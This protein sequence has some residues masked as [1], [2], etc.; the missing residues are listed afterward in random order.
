MANLL[1][2]VLLTTLSSAPAIRPTFSI[3]GLVGVSGTLFRDATGAVTTEGAPGTG[4]YTRTGILFAGRI[5]VE[6]EV[7]VGTDLFRNFWHVAGTLEVVPLRV[8]TVAAGPV[9]GGFNTSA[10]AVNDDK[11]A[12]YF[13]GTLRL[14][15]HPW[16]SASRYGATF[17]L[18]LD[19]RKAT[20]LPGG[21]FARGP[22]TP[23]LTGATF[24]LVGYAY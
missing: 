1:G 5:G 16:A 10:G 14:D 18:V 3:G 12:H 11:S 7:L 19:L 8:L 22:L 4:L 17:S 23:L 24:A 9:W 6:G 2:L 20:G 13:G 15:L 21:G